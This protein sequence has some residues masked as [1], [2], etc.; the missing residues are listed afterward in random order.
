MVFSAQSVHQSDSVLLAAQV[1]RLLTSLAIRR[2]FA[3]PTNDRSD[4]VLS[5]GTPALGKR[6]MDEEMV[7][8]WIFLTSI[9]YALFLSVSWVA[10]WFCP[11]TLAM[12]TLLPAVVKVFV[13]SLP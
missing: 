13:P 1:V 11:A 2:Y 6:L 3:C 9:H 10:S 8:G 12:K 7:V 5:V 4:H